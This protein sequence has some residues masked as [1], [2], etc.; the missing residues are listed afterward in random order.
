MADRIQVKVKLLCFAHRDKRNRWI[1]E[2][3][4]LRIASQGKTLEAAKESLREAI[5]LWFESCLERDTLDEAM[6]ELGFEHASA[7]EVAAADEGVLIV[8][9][10]AA[11]ETGDSFQLDITIPAYQ[12]AALL[13]SGGGIEA[14]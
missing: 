3:H 8:G 13:S 5:Q 6:R 10:P 14:G 11:P 1:T 9:A 12:A 4:R 7:E 2:C